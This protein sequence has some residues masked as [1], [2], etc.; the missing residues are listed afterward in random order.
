MNARF[1]FFAVIGLLLL[2]ASLA[3]RHRDNERT[4]TVNVPQMASERDVRIV[5][6]AALDEIRGR[7]DGI[8]HAYQVDRR[9]HAVIYHEGRRLLDPAFRAQ[10]E[11]RIREIGF[12][13]HFTQAAANP[14]PPLR[15]GRGE[16]FHD[17]PGRITGVIAVPGLKSNTDANRIVNAISLA[18]SGDDPEHVHLD[19]DARTLSVTFNGLLTAPRNIEHAIACSGFAANGVPPRL[20][21]QDA[22]AFGWGALDADGG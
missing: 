4:V 6:N 11:R 12:D 3:S 8:R 13:A 2:C 22:V 15:N 18:R 19:R 14:P 17:W 16:L 9:N 20:G 10:I 5:T 21:Q 1:W 7:Y